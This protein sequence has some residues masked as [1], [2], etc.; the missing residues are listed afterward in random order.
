M[1][2]SAINASYVGPG[3]FTPTTGLSRSASLLSVSRR[4]IGVHKEVDTLLK[5]VSGLDRRMTKS[6]VALVHELIATRNL[7]VANADPGQVRPLHFGASEPIRNFRISEAGMGGL[8]QEISPTVAEDKNLVRRLKNFVN[9]SGPGKNAEKH[10]RDAVFTQAYANQA[11]HEWPSDI[12]LHILRIGNWDT[13]DLGEMDLKRTDFQ[14][15]QWPNA[16]L[17]EVELEGSTLC[18]GDLSRSDLKKSNLQRTDLRRA[19]LSRADMELATADGADM[20]GADLRVLNAKGAFFLKVL[21]DGADTERA[22]F[23]GAHLEYAKGF[24]ISKGLVLTDAW[25]GHTELVLNIGECK[26]HKAL[27][28]KLQEVLPTLAT[29]ARRHDDVYNAAIHK[30][31]TL[32]RDFDRGSLIGAMDPKGMPETLLRESRGWQDVRIRGFIDS[33]VLPQLLT[34]WN[35]NAVDDKALLRQV[36]SYLTKTK[37]VLDWPQYCGAIS[38]LQVDAEH[39]GQFAKRNALSALLKMHPGIAPLAAA[40]AAVDAMPEAFEECSIFMAPAQ[41]RAIVYSNSRLREIVEGRGSPYNGYYFSQ[42]ENGAWRPGVL[43]SLDEIENCKVPMDLYR[44]EPPPIAAVKL[45]STIFEGSA[46]KERFIDALTRK[47]MIVALESDAA[48]FA[49]LHDDAQLTAHLSKY[50][51]LGKDECI[52]MVQCKNLWKVFSASTPA[53]EK[54]DGNKA[55]MLACLGTLFVRYSSAALFGTET[56]S[57]KSLRDFAWGC[58]HAAHMFDASLLGKEQTLSIRDTLKGKANHPQCTENLTQDLLALIHAKIE[59]DKDIEL[60]ICFKAIYP[61]SGL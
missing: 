49:F 1:F 20:R 61:Q 10:L 24:R 15:V 30:I 5:A 57:L 4:K 37:P 34:R 36:M 53:L 22:D 44:V 58:F 27:D 39:A 51:T 45:L 12:A 21:F 56:E 52:N 7:F 43:R 18:D 38:Q 33:A 2:P 23:S 35:V 3:M 26:T 40:V 60:A 46:F 47:S 42:E 17:T 32:I 9:L 41:D 19:N 54:N 13:V 29:I 55:R 8:L 25:L 28:Q 6:I 16:I 50:F 14:G 48:I 31:I 11:P 59:R